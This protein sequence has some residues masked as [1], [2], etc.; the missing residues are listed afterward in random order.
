MSILLQLITLAL[1]TAAAA[2]KKEVHPCNA[3]AYG[4]DAMAY[5]ACRAEYSLQMNWYPDPIGG[6]FSYQ[7]WNGFDGF[8]QNGIVL[9]ALV[10]F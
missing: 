10:N 5:Q 9:E 4:G 6:L 2:A 1:V 3:T 7:T 8:W